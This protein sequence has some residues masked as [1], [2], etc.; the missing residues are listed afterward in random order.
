MSEQ[1]KRKKIR[2]DVIEDL[3]SYQ[4][5]SLI[6]SISSEF[7]DDFPE[8]IPEKLR[9][10]KPKPVIKSDHPKKPRSRTISCQSAEE[11]PILT[12]KRTRVKIDYKECLSKYNAIDKLIEDAAK[13][14]TKYHVKNLPKAKKVVPPPKVKK[15]SKKKKKLSVSSKSKKSK[16][17]SSSDS[18]SSESSSSSDSSSS[19]S[20]SS[21]SSSSDDDNDDPKPKQTFSDLKAIIAKDLQLSDSSSDEEE[22]QSEAKKARVVP[23]V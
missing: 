4:L 23:Q 18:S 13:D 12:G 8:I 14:T 5:S 19:S 20:S 6:R 17:K 2:R 22:T 11:S 16:S 7:N 21:E 15:P 10:K 1:L 9:Y 3:V